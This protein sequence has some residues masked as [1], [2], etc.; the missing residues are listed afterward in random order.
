M[1][2]TH[3]ALPRPVAVGRWLWFTAVVTACI[4]AVLQ[5]VAVRAVEAKLLAAWMGSLLP[6]GVFAVD[7]KFV[8]SNSVD[9]PVAFDVTAECTALVLVVPLALLVGFMTLHRG[10]SLVRSALALTVSVAVMAFINQGRL[11]LIAW[12]TH[13]WG[14]DPGYEVT[15]ALLGSLLSLIGFAFGVLLVLRTLGVVRG[16]GHVR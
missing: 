8:I 2:G 12:A 6:G 9:G 5:N 11:G 14:I 13:Y 7:T 3:V 10:T 1:T 15:H 4:A 16:K